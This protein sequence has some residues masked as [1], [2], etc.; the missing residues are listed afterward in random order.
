MREKEPSGDGS[1][2]KRIV[3]VLFRSIAI[4]IFLNTLT[5][6]GKVEDRK[7]DTRI[8]VELTDLDLR[9]FLDADHD[10]DLTEQVDKPN[11]RLFSIGIGVKKRVVGCRLR[12]PAASW[13]ANATL[14]SP[15]IILL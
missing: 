4:R 6:V 15:I 2:S 3:N 12:D 5:G 10:R 1:R 8:G 14:L 11:R 9:V 7:R 13:A